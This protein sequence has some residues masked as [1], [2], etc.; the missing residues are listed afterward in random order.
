MTDSSPEGS[1]RLAVASVYYL[2]VKESIVLPMP[3]TEMGVWASSRNISMLVLQWS[4]R[5]QLINLL[6]YLYQMATRLNHHQSPNPA[7]QLHERLNPANE[8]L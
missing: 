7:H 1:A 8:L 3:V 4:G 6:I 5:N 2:L